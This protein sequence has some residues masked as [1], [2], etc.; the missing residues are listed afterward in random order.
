MLL[1]LAKDAVREAPDL[2]PLVHERGELA[3]PVAEGPPDRRRTGGERAER[4]PAAGRD[5]LPGGERRLRGEHGYAG[6][7]RHVRA[8][9]GGAHREA[10]ED[11]SGRP[12]IDP[13]LLPR[14]AAGGLLAGLVGEGLPSRPPHLS[15][16]P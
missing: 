15:P 1:E 4:R 7:H 6:H 10:A 14:L 2:E 5:L 9:R 16:P 11:R 3:F 8:V 13:D 12:E